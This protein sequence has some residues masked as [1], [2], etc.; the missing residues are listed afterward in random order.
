MASGP[1]FYMV[2][3]QA[4]PLDAH[5][6]VLRGAVTPTASGRLPPGPNLIRP[7]TPYPRSV[8]DGKRGISTKKGLSTI[9]AKD[10]IDK[11]SSSVMGALFLKALRCCR[12]NVPYAMEWVGVPRWFF[13][14]YHANA[15]ALPTRSRQLLFSIP[16]IASGVVAASL[17]F[18]MLS[19]FS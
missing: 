9:V 19:Q 5:A 10:R 15:E 14:L 18:H 13:I 1:Y 17:M 4:T 7:T 16:L 2:S 3:T 11:T 6:E 8:A 12:L